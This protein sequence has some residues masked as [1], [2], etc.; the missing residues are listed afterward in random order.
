M[1]CCKAGWL[2]GP[3]GVE[4]L[5]ARLEGCCS[6]RA[7]PDVGQELET[8]LIKT[9]RR[10]QEPMQQ[11]TDRFETG[12]QY[13][14]RA[15]A[16]ASG[17]TVPIPSIASSGQKPE[18]REY[19]DGLPEDNEDDDSRHW[20]AAGPDADAEAAA[21][22]SEATGSSHATVYLAGLPPDTAAQDVMIFFSR[23]DM[24]QHIADG[25]EQVR[26]F[27]KMDGSKA[28]SAAVALRGPASVDVV[29]R[30]L[31]L[32][33]MGSGCVEVRRHLQE[34]L[35]DGPEVL[36][37]KVLGWLMLVRSGL[38]PRE[39]A[40]ILATTGGSLDL[41]MIRENLIS[42]WEDDNLAE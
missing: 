29:A 12:Y 9:K 3:D 20:S 6:H 31:H 22:A 17:H 36:P 10:R 38:D 23:H 39:R 25:K 35:A 42:S 11:W 30:A 28:G 27:P 33:Q 41:N 32:K 18:R 1:E 8:F 5:L 16:R 37:S 13:L 15:L 24:V 34:K 14:K 21:P 26:I 2:S 4:V 7:V 40:A 19:T